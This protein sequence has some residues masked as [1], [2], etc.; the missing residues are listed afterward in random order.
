MHHRACGLCW[1][2]REPLNPRPGF[3]A[4]PHAAGSQR[5]AGP[6]RRAGRAEASPGR[7]GK[8]FT[9]TQVGMGR[10]ANREAD[11]ASRR[12][13]GVP[14]PRNDDMSRKTPSASLLHPTDLR[15]SSRPLGDRR[16]QGRSGGNTRPASRAPRAGGREETGNCAGLQGRPR[17]DSRPRPA[18]SPCPRP[19]PRP[20]LPTSPVTAPPTP[21]SRSTPPTPL[22]PTS[23][24]P[25]RSRPA[26]GLASLAPA[27]R[28]RARCLV[29]PS[30]S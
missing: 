12:L 9:R 23:P 17:P 11:E 30:A 27:A 8:T 10:R 4:I 1:T 5:K 19:R 3:W 6:T 21:R 2:Q 28:T 29:G 7:H 20:A 16:S 18:I 25:A 15:P 13:R 26:P 24:V 22:P 14:E